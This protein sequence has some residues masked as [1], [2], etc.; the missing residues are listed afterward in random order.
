M[1]CCPMTGTNE[2][3]KAGFTWCRFDAFILANTSKSY[4]K[5]SLDFPVYFAFF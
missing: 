2:K 3:L 5:K 1:I 4:K